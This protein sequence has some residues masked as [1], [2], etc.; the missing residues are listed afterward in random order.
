MSHRDS[1]CD[2]CYEELGHGAW[3]FLAPGQRALCLDCADLGHL[4]FLPS[5][6]AAV[7][8]RVKKNSR[9]TV[10]V[11]KW[12]RARRRYE[13]QGFLVEEDA[14]NAAEAECLADAE[15]RQRQRERASLRRAELDDEFIGRFADQVRTLFPGCPVDREQVI[16]EHACRKYSGRVGRSA[17]ARELDPEAVRLAVVARVRH[18]ETNYDVLLGRGYDRGDA[19][20]RVWLQVERIV[21]AWRSFPSEQV[22]SQPH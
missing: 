21:D 22:S 6:D 18:A 13:R 2:E 15:V 19:R 4:M 1:V 3:I 8:R 10:V 14:L 20:E 7:T 5:G 12:S 9:L 11:L 17:A 16:A